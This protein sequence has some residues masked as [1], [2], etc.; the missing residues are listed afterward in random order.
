MKVLISR[1]A[2]RTIFLSIVLTFLTTIVLIKTFNMVNIKSITTVKDID[3]YE[4]QNRLLIV[5]MDSI[6]V[7]TPEDAAKVWSNG[8]KMRSGAMQYSVM[9]KKLKNEYKED[10]EK[11]F[12]NWVTGVSSPWINSFKITK[13][14]KYNDSKYIYTVVF[15]TKTS[16]GAAGEYI[17]K[18][19]VIKELNFWRISNVFADKELDVYTGFNS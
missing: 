16:T 14:D 7:C 1:K 9:T 17:A 19:T 11:S 12:P 5:A 2:T 10:L 3:K 4:I 15:Y 13:M 6:G 8:L 18:L